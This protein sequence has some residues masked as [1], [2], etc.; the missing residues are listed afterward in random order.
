[1]HRIM[2]F[3]LGVVL[4]AF[5]CGMLFTFRVNFDEVALVTTFGRATHKSVVNANGNQAGLHL[6]W[7]WPI[8]WKTGSSNRRQR[9]GTW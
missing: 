6:K 7:P 8:F 3:I 4:F 9:T 1:M 5:F 2:K